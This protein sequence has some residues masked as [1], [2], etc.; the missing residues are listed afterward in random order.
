MRGISGI[1]IDFLSEFREI[2]ILITTLSFTEMVIKNVAALKSVAVSSEHNPRS[3]S[4]CY[5]TDDRVFNSIYGRRCSQ[6][7]QE[8]TP[9]LTIDLEIAFDVH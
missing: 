7:M 1:E 9:W 4:P 5:A 3:H 2:L 6:T 8:I